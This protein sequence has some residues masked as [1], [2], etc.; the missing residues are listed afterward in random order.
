MPDPPRRDDWRRIADQR[1]HTSAD[2]LTDL[3][4]DDGAQAR[5]V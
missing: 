4:S 5:P 2:F 1:D 3:F